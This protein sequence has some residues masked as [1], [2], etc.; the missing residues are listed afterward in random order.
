MRTGNRRA[1]IGQVIEMVLKAFA[2][3]MLL[4][5][6]TA[7]AQTVSGT[8]ISRTTQQPVAQAMVSLVQADGAIV[9]AL[10]TD[11][12]GQYSFEL[13]VSGEH[14][15]RAERFGFHTYQTNPMQN[16]GTNIRQD[17]QLQDSV[18][19]LSPVTVPAAMRSRRLASIGLYER[20][21]SG[22]GTFI[23]RDEIEKRH[24]LRITDVLEGRAGIRVIQ[25]SRATSALSRDIV[26]RAGATNRMRGGC[27]PR[28]YLDGVLVRIGG[29]ANNA[30][31]VP[32]DEIATLDDVEGIELYKSAAQVPAQYGGANSACGVVLIWSRT[33]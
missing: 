17:V 2:S 16:A 28:V 23:L 14:R 12:S 3:M 30:L 24:G 18:I 31:I 8:I 22:I 25:A 11:A 21:Q 5:S 32:L 33:S 29:S 1:D 13:P 7:S 27:L 4:V 10:S 19:P 6:A 20:A 15:I 9:R 26:M